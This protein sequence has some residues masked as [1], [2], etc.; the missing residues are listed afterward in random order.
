[1]PT[2]LYECSSCEKQFEAEQRITEDPLTAC[3]CGAE[4]TVKRLIQPTAILFKG[5]GFYINDSQPSSAR[6]SAAECTGTG[7]PA[8][9]PKCADVEAKSD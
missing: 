8:S 7:E 2:Y 3:P 1:M 4:G 9:C 6:D 5:S